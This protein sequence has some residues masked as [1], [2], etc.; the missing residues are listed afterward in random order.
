MRKTSAKQHGSSDFS[1]S[2]PKSKYAIILS[3]VRVITISL[4]VT[5][6]LAVLAASA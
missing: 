6:P 4:Q 2:N 5:G 1:P 3:L